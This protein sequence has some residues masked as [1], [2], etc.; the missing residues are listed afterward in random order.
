MPSVPPTFPSLEIQRRWSSPILGRPSLWHREGNKLIPRV[1]SGIRCGSFMIALGP[2]L[3]PIE[4][5]CRPCH[6]GHIA[7]PFR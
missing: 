6:T 1:A 2:R 7:S 4:S 5:G 3:R